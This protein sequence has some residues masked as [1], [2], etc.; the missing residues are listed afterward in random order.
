MKSCVLAV[1][2]KFTPELLSYSILQIVAVRVIVQWYQQDKDLLPVQ[3]AIL[4]NF[5]LS[6][7]YYQ[8]Y[9]ML[10]AVL[11]KFK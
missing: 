3:L 5:N 9:V 1:I 11:L 4:E 10:F 2:N 6:N 7:Y 8:L